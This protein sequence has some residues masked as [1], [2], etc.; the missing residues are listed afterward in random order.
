[1]R[2]VSAVLKN[3]TRSPAIIANV[4]KWKFRSVNA[5]ALT[6]RI[7][8]DGAVGA[9]SA[10]SL[11]V[12]SDRIG[13]AL[14][15]FN[16]VDANDCNS[17]GSDTVVTC[18]QL[19]FSIPIRSVRQNPSK[20]LYRKKFISSEDKEALYEL[21]KKHDV[22]AY[23]VS[24]PIQPDTGLCGAGCGRTLFALEQLV[25]HNEDR[26]CAER[27]SRSSQQ[28]KNGIFSPTR[29]ICFWSYNGCNY[30]KQLHRRRDDKTQSQS[31]IYHSQYDRYHPADK[32]GRK[33]VYARTSSRKIYFASKEQY[34]PY[35]SIITATKVW[36]D[37]YKH[38]WSPVLE[39]SE[40][41]LKSAPCEVSGKLHGHESSVDT[42]QQIPNNSNADE[43][44]KE[45][46]RKGKMSEL[47]KISSLVNF[48]N[49]G[50]GVV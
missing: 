21:V 32:F 38:H 3:V 34:K 37:F 5:A 11:D 31:N 33:S 4:L 13:L 8:Y 6:D 42:G 10:M 49:I 20:P 47:R 15:T 17:A 25:R 36:N 50:I 35:E 12:H 40:V 45:M 30:D 7:D 28:Q 27:Q 26:D 23:V 18:N 16:V 24:W 41:Y 43:P 2:G 29:P 22:C 46:G 44:K 1:M 39:T 14:A 9:V 48:R 19:D